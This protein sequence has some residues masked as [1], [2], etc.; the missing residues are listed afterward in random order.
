M[1]YNVAAQVKIYVDEPG[2]MEGV[3]AKL[4]EFA[5][6]NKQWEEDVGF[7]IK[8]LKVVFLFNDAAGGMDQLEEKLRALPHVSEVEVEEVSR[9]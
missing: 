2:E 9:I 6:V 8:A 7:G 4:A 5:K 3:K 1:E